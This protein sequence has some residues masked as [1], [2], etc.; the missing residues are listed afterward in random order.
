VPVYVLKQ[1]IGSAAMEKPKE[2]LA[3]EDNEE[4]AHLRDELKWFESGNGPGPWPSEPAAPGV[5][6]RARA[7]PK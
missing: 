5:R 4:A 2:A 3:A 1:G 6:V 7:R